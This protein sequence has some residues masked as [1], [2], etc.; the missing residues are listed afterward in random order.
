MGKKTGTGAIVVP[1]PTI[2]TIFDRERLKNDEFKPFIYTINFRRKNPRTGQVE[3][4]PAHGITASGLIRAAHPYLTNIQSD[5]LHYGAP[6]GRKILS[7]VVRVT[8]TALVVARL[9][10]GN[11]LHEIKMSAL[12]D[13]DVTG[14]PSADTLVRTVETRALNRALERLLDIS[15]ADLNPD[16]VQDEE[17]Y[18]IPLSLADRLESQRKKN[19]T[20]AA[21]EARCIRGRG[22]C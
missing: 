14:V 5:V 7:C 16:S 13:G 3:S 21:E 18:G 22:R 2:P 12:A 9:D 10:T 8:V 15:K 6:E 19:D 11:V 4:I 1:E 17:E 20:F